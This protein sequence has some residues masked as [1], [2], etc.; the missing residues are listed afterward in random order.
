MEYLK[1]YFEKNIFHQQKKLKIHESNLKFQ[2][3]K[4]S[5]EN[6]LIALIFNVLG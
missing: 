1:F 5:V 6:S 2:S 3:E 4:I